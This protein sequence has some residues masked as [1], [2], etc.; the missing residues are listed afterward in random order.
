VSEGNLIHETSYP[1]RSQKYTEV[2]LEGI[3]IDFYDPENKVVHEVKKS[4]KRE[5]AHEWQVKYYIYK[6]QENGIE[7][8]SGILEYPKLR[9]TSEIVLSERDIHEINEM[10]TAISRIIHEEQAP[11]KLERKYCKNCSYIDFCWT[12]EP[13]DV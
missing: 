5:L 7:G 3:K 8:V 11:G 12:N 13:N 9:Q 1:Q 4:K 10:T 6:L 2:E